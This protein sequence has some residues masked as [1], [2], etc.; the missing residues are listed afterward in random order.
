MAVITQQ[1][2]THQRFLV[3]LDRFGYTFNVSA[4][5]YEIFHHGVCVIRLQ[6]RTYNQATK[7]GENHLKS[8]LYQAVAIHALQQNHQ[9]STILR[10]EE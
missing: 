5:S 1:S 6:K 9:L 3:L 7:E 10:N 4:N 8:D 2:L